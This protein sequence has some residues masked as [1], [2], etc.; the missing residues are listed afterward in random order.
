MK[1]TS[2]DLEESYSRQASYVT[3]YIQ[4]LEQ[5]ASDEIAFENLPARHILWPDCIFLDE[6]RKNRVKLHTT[7]PNVLPPQ[8]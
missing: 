6:V 3:G 2:K 5:V 7:A 1:N 8:F 4:L